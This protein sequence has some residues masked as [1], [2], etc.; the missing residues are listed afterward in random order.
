[1]GQL[2]NSLASGVVGGRRWKTVRPSDADE[3][4]AARERR[5]AILSLA[6]PRAVGR[7]VAD[8]PWVMGYEFGERNLPRSANPY[9]TSSE[10]G[11]LWD[12]GWF[13]GAGMTS[14]ASR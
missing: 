14:E 5:R 1:M 6:R 12:R 8:D 2:M 3:A 10:S 13:E 11:A 9:S 7:P 4:Q